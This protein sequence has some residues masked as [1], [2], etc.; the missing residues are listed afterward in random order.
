MK[1]KQGVVVI[2]T[3]TVMLIGLISFLLNNT[4]FEPNKPKKKTNNQPDLPNLETPIRNDEMVKK[5]KTD[6]FHTQLKET[7][8]KLQSK[9]WNDKSDSEK[10]L[11]ISSLSE[12]DLKNELE[13]LRSLITKNNFY[14]GLENNEYSETEERE[15][16][17]ILEKFALIGLERTRRKFMSIEPELQ[18]P[19][20]AHEESLKEIRELLSEL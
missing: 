14:N 7:P 12:S 9:K 18:D 1:T 19:I 8:D 13:L 11:E 5:P 4:S 2:L 6:L 15:A 16:K 3:S 17:G 20:S 10:I